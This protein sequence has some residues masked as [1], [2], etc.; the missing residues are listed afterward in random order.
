MSDATNKDPQDHIPNPAP[1]Q[2]ENP[3]EQAQPSV[4]QEPVKPQP[5]PG[6]HQVGIA[7]ELEP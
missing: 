4:T 1:D 3:L 7:L 2:D 5:R 6:A